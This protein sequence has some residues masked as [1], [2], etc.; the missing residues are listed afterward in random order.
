MMFDLVVKNGRIVTS[1]QI[2]SA[3][4]GVKGEKIAAIFAPGLPFEAR[5]V[6]DAKGKYVFPGGIDS[7]AH[8]NDPGYNWR[9]D[10]THGTAAAIVGGYTTIIDMPLQNEPAMTNGNIMDK[11]LEIV[12]PQA[13]TDYCFWGGLVDYNFADLTEHDAKGCVAF[14]ILIGR[15]KV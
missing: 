10:Y 1:D 2:F 7:H 12:A 5:D 6:V 13:Y 11:K 4:V 9:E 14:K 15:A 8:L 3:N